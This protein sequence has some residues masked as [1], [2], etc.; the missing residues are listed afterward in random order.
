MRARNLHQLDDKG[1]TEEFARAADRLGQ[2]VV[3]WESGVKE[4]RY[5]FAIRDVVRER[6][7]HTLAKLLPLLDDR[8]RFVQYYAA[9][10]LHA[11]APE[12][13]R[14]IIEDNAKQGDAIAG[15]AGMHLS[16]LDNGLYK[17]D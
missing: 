2:A 13:C 12:R 1:L 9:R 8:N 4:T 17:P 10:Q 15:D 6:G 14:Q 7:R 3:N 16:A 11:L 5:L